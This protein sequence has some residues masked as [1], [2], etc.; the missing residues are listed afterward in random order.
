MVAC[1]AA[2]RVTIL[3]LTLL[4][5]PS[6]LRGQITVNS[7]SSNST[8]AAASLTWP[9]TITSGS[10]RALLVGISI[11]N[12]GSSTGV[13]YGG[14]PLTLVGRSVG[15]HTVE[16][17]RLLAPPVGPANIVASFGATNQV[18]GGAAA[19]NGVSQTT[20]TGTF[21]G[22]GGVST[23][24]SV[25]ISSATG[26]LVLDVLYGNDG[27]TATPGTGQTTQWSLATGS[28]NGKVRGAGSTEA[29][30][31]TATMS[32]TL[33][34][35]VEWQ[36]G[37]VSIKPAPTS[38][39]GDGTDPSN[40]SLAPGG[41]ATMA[42]AFTLQTNSGTDAITAATVTL[43]TGTSGGL[44]LVEITNDA[45]TVVYGSVA[46]PGSDTPAITLSTNITATTTLTQYKIRVTPKTHANMPAPV[47]SSYAVTA[48]I[49]AW[50]GTNVQLGADAA[51]TTVTI[52]NL[53]PGNVTASTATAGVGQ[54][55]LA[56]T[57]PGDAD[58]GSIIVL[59][60]TVS[61]VTDTPAEGTAYTV[62]NTI[63][64]STVACVVTA[65]TASC[66]DTGLTS[67]I[68]YYYRVFTRD[69]NGN[70]GTGVVPG[71]SPATPLATTLGNGTD[72]SNASLAP[73]GAATMAGAFTLQTSSGTDA[74]TA[75]TLT[76]ASGTSAGLS[77]V[78]ITNDAGTVVYGSVANPGSDT[79][80]ITL[81]TNITAT[82]TLT[83]YKIRVTPKSHVNM[84]AP[85]GASYAV[86]ARVSAWTGTNGQLGSDAAGT[87]VTIDN[88]SP[89]I[90]TA[91]TATAGLSQVALAWTNPGDADLGSIVVLR[92]TVSAV[93]DTPVEGTTYTVGNTIGASTVACVVTAPTASCTNTGLT[94]GTA[95]Y[96]RVFTRDANGNYGTGVVPTGSPATP[97]A[98]T[99]GNGTDPSNASLAPGGAATMAG[100]FTLQTSGG[101]DAITA[102]TV[103]LATGTSAG[104]SL[105]EITNDAGTVVYG[106]V[107]NPGSGTPAIPLTTNITATTTLTQYKIRVTPKSH[108]N[109]PAPAGASYAVTARISAWTGTNGQAGSDA[110]GTT[111]T[112]D[113]LSPG[114][115]TASTATAGL[116]QVALAWTNPGVA[117]LSSIV[118][119][120]RTV[121]AVTD[122]PV[123][124]TT[125]TVG[126]TIGASTVACVVTAPTASC[127]D[128]GLTNGTAYYYRVFT[129]D[130]NGN[131]GTGV[132]PT[133]SP[134]TPVAT[135]LGNGTDPSNASLAPGGSAT[136]AD[137]FTLQ[138]SSGTDA[139][140]AMTVTLA[141]GT[142]GGL[143]LVEITNDAG[144]VVYGSVANPGSDTPAL[145]LTT[146][147]TATTTLTQ[148]KIRVTPK[149]HV[150]MPAPIGSSYAV[151][152][153][154]S[155]WTGT[156]GQAGSDAAGTTV[157]IDNLSPGNVTASTATA[158]LSQVAL[159]WTNPG[160]ADLGSIVV[161]RRTVSAV[162]DTPV[163]GATYTIGNT[164]GSSTVAC[165]ITAPTASCTDTGLTNGTA[166]YHRVFTRDANGNYST[167]VVP[168]GSPATPVATTLGNGTDPSNA[169]LAPG[170]AATMA[171]A[172]T[173]QTS[174]GTDAITAVTV[175]LAT[176][177]SAGVS[178][179][180]ITND[181][182]SVVYGSVV[183]PGSDTP[184]ITLTTNI[185]AT[186][187]LTQYKIRVT[188]KSHVNMPAPVGS[189]YAVTGLI[190]AWTGTNG[191]AGTDAA[192]TT[193]T[194]D[195]L[196]PGNVTAST[197]TAG[198]SQVA[199][200][201]TNPGDADL[202]SI[203][204]LRRTV[205][206]VTDTPVEGTTY[207][208]GTTIGASTVACVITAPTA[209]C[210]DTGLTNGTVYY[211][212]VFARD[213]NGNY[214]T[215]AVP[216]GSPA[217]PVATTLGN[218]TDPSNASLAPGG[219]A[220]MA[221]A[222]TF[223]TSNGTDAI[224][225]VTVT[226]ATG[227]SA[228]L[229]LVE[230]TNDAGTVVYGS[231]TNPGS[232]TPAITLTTN[233][234]ATATLTQYKIRVTPK[235]H[236]NMPV[237][238]GASYAVTALISAWT[239]TN[240]PAGSDAAGTT[241]TIDNLSPGNVT[242]STATAG[243]T[244]VALAWTNPGDADLGS[245]I[246]LRRT[247][248]VVTDTPIEGTTYTVG[249][250]I[251]SSTVACVVTAP[252]AS[253]TDTGLTNGTA[254][255]YR[256]F[257][258]D[259]NGNYATGVV[260]TGSPTTPVAPLLT[261]TQAASPGG[262]QPPGTDITFTSTYTNTGT[263][264]AQGL[265]IANPVAANTDF[266]LG[267]VT[268]APG[269]TGLT[270]VVAYSSNGGT[271]W[272]YTPVSGAGG[273]PAGYD[274]LVTDIR[275]T[276]TGTL[277]QTAP[278]NTG[279][280]AVV[281]R[282]R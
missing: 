155:A 157:T 265:V 64:V 96:Y 190:S 227:T 160:D 235:S 50:T 159:A 214:A 59:R 246:V 7:T 249:T 170:G 240:G 109:M 114:N 94:N 13:T 184:T 209:S 41:A 192:G 222:F 163:E 177:T 229:S 183:N 238:A 256:V 140:T 81:T 269:T 5:G 90:V 115:V 158:G 161:L 173:L 95:Y 211:Y 30:A 127:T 168:T 48:R 54:V 162:T 169:S 138:T 219:A 137:A 149:T 204:V 212:R 123:E 242:A 146:N 272:T 220:T 4:V 71:G 239:G 208:V 60:R 65:P 233:I 178:L 76:L 210:T 228:G 97:V 261:L 52:D 223:Q 253:C 279:S 17:W 91:S 20:P 118:V 172:F 145:T 47:G 224:T 237:P 142:S 88:L 35:S 152:A 139:I 84:P 260:P 197:A 29:G 201:W 15:T 77:L 69:A 117:D 188:P 174:S 128:T 187:T 86:T 231:V 230:I 99:L 263:A 277:S 200:A 134:A 98:T 143:S 276:F 213:A 126:A 108:V 100:A 119:L 205:S 51:G 130:A 215:G 2:V 62:G 21:A 31:P 58:L 193:V 82:T 273:A 78:E 24:P 18:V 26:E 113:N 40:A 164:I 120:R 207:T 221:G 67:G 106:S 179:V 264:P 278:N 198:L 83:Q 79:P 9:H 136:M 101:T 38:T 116:S 131:Y 132:V 225:A 102:A 175:T 49:S 89:G 226:V 103:T 191:Q 176:G 57:N 33:S 189:S 110:A 250:T 259:A 199:L 216:T 124:G 25:N 3:V 247:V 266:K 6:A 14:T 104:L 42:D 43:A 32:W 45:G 262:T 194:I 53:S 254:Y 105:V 196:S 66:T 39:L 275:W 171:D 92:R 274:R 11:E 135:T 36:I 12:G 68:A 28:G 112:I 80:A 85:V 203:V 74:I 244:Q 236:V 218:G 181:A 180:E 153:R 243:G 144:T 165:V 61:A 111:V 75:A 16:L 73:G 141:T 133:G 195:N 151:T 23:A 182:G 107:A 27:P 55:A 129:R 202:G 154:I 186:T 206:A 34:S 166:Y 8:T 267:S 10:N 147:I 245:I 281:L 122:T 271:T 280:V 46:N 148:Y 156:K 248:S 121:S 255:Y 19:F 70:Y 241:V 282:I 217:T 232:D 72:P 251:G 252:T 268:S 257:T 63:G 167:G 150:N 185:T 234:T 44:S 56:W 87:T 258:R 270:V 22:A 93:T 37:G 1:R 125:Y